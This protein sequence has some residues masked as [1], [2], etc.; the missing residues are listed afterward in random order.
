[1]RY[2]QTQIY[3]RDCYP[4]TEECDAPTSSSE[5]ASKEGNCRSSNRNNAPNEDGS[6]HSSIHGVWPRIGE[7]RDYANGVADA[8]AALNPT[9]TARCLGSAVPMLLVADHAQTVNPAVIS[10]RIVIP[11]NAAP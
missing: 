3:K 11:K 2:K 1:M 10:A 8:V 9:K 6:L 4:R 5:K 7:E